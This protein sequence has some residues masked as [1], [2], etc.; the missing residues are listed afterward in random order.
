M[1][2]CTGY[3]RTWEPFSQTGV[4]FGCDGGADGLNIAFRFANINSPVLGQKL[5]EQSAFAL[6]GDCD[7]LPQGTL[8]VSFYY[9]GSG[10][11]SNILSREID[12]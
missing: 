12:T 5:A 1:N 3:I 10:F 11:A 6:P 9:D 2:N 7:T 4:I 8:S